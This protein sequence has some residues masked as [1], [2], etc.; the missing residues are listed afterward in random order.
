MRINTKRIR[1]RVTKMNNA[2]KQGA[3][4]ATFKG[5]KQP[6]FQAKIEDG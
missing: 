5:I 4:N 2:W 6:D 3:A 1:E